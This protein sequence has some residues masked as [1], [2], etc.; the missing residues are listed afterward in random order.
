VQIERAGQP[1]RLV[2]G[3]VFDYLKRELARRRVDDPSLPFDFT[4]GYVGYFGYEMKAECGAVNRH[5]AAMPDASWLFAD[6]LVVV[7]HQD[8]SPTCCAWPRTPRPRAPRRP[9]G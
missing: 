4:G 5:R 1:S 7:D 2:A 8:R 3:N 6:R 9:P